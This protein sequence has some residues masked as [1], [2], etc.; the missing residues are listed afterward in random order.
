MSPQ[1]FV[2]FHQEG[3][4]ILWVQVRCLQTGHTQKETDLVLEVTLPE[5]GHL[6]R[7][8]GD[9]LWTH[10]KTKWLEKRVQ[11]KQILIFIYIYQVEVSGGGIT[12]WTISISISNEEMK[13]KGK[14]FTL[15]APLGS[16]L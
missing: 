10:L 9:V 16:V 13:G 11:R 15:M 3:T 7:E 14:I 4:E 2:Q 12:L 1:S 5:V 8:G 6:K